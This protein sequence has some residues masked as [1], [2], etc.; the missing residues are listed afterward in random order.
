MDNDTHMFVKWSEQIP[1][2]TGAPHAGIAQDAF[3]HTVNNEVSTKTCDLEIHI[4][5]TPYYRDDTVL[6]LY[7]HEVPGHK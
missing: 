5:D 3:V 7:L 2:Y 6:L 1:G 4:Q